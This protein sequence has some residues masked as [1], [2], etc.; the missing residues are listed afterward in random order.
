MTDTHPIPPLGILVR[1][2]TSTEKASS[3]RTESATRNWFLESSL[4][5]CATRRVRVSYVRALQKKA[6][7]PSRMLLLLLCVLLLSKHTKTR[8]FKAP[9]GKDLFNKT[10]IKKQKNR[11]RKKRRKP[12]CERIRGKTREEEKEK[13]LKE[14]EA[15]QAVGNKE[16]GRKGRYS[17]SKETGAVWEGGGGGGGGRG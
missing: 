4:A 7:S 3:A 14:K 1:A 17:I 10:L 12:G 13:R 8:S 5:Y 6:L 15:R 9:G 11:R 2:G 16:V